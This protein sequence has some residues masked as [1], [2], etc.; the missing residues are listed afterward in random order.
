MPTMVGILVMVQDVLL[1]DL[2]FVFRCHG[3]RSPSTNALPISKKPPQKPNL[4][5]PTGSR[6]SLA[7]LRS[8][9]VD[10]HVDNRHLATCRAKDVSRV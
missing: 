2:F 6:P 8:V 3:S 9:W 1:I 4:P 7:F 5:L 10:M